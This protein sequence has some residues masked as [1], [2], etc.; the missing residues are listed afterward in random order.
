MSEQQARIDANALDLAAEPAGEATVDG[1]TVEHDR[2]LGPVNAPLYA[3]LRDGSRVVAVPAD[4]GL[5]KELSGRS[6]VGET[7]RIRS[8]EGAPV[9]EL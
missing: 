2:E 1:F 4:R 6:L 9:Y 8:G 5:P 7:V 3:T